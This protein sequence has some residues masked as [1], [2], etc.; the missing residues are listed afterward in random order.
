MELDAQYGLSFMSIDGEWER[1]LEGLNKNTNNA[2][3]FNNN[4]RIFCLQA[5]YDLLK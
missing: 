3:F 2:I 1:I 5:I 4:V